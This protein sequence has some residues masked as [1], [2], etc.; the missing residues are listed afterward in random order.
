VAE[1]KQSQ[2]PRLESKQNPDQERKTV[3]TSLIL[4]SEIIAKVRVLARAWDR[5]V[6]WTVRDLIE[7][8]LASHYSE[9]NEFASRQ[10]IEDVQIAKI[11]NKPLTVETNAQLVKR[12]LAEEKERNKAEGTKSL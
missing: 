7:G 4:G 3:P 11:K 9:L 5:T 8:A 2:D 6:S 1:P 12:I 10:A